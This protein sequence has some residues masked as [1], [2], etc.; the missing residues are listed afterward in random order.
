MN[1]KILQTARRR[2]PPR[3]FSYPVGAE[4]LSEAFADLPQF[5]EVVLDFYVP[6]KHSSATRYLMTIDYNPHGVGFGLDSKWCVAV[7]SVPSNAKKPVRE[8]LMGGG[9]AR[10]REWIIQ[11]RPPLW[12]EGWKRLILEYDPARGAILYKEEGK[13]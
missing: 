3:G 11:P 6:I 12:F 10:I 7:C 4:I 5:D 2:K 8:A 9:F 13:I 1:K